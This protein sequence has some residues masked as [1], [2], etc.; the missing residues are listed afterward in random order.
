MKIL[1]RCFLIAALYSVL[2][3]SVW[4][5]DFIQ[6]SSLTLG[7]RNYFINSDNRE[8]PAANQGNIAGTDLPNGSFIAAEDIA[9]II[10]TAYQMP[11]SSL[12]EDIV[13]RP[14]AGDI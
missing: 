3:Q 9:N 8:I 1:R 11:Y 2:N 14:T 7:L 10:F 12:V 6:D 13:I 5:D 4:S